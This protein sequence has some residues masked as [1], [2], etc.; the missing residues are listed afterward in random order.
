MRLAFLLAPCAFA[1]TRGGKL[2]LTMDDGRACTVEVTPTTSGEA[3]LMTNCA[4]IVNGVDV[5]A[6]AARLDAV[7]AHLGWLPPPSPP[8]SPLP[9]APPPPPSPPSAPSPSPP[10]IVAR[11]WQQIGSGGYCRCSSCS[12]TTGGASDF[13]KL[14]LP[15]T[16]SACQKACA[17]NAPCRAYECNFDG[18]TCELWT[19]V[20]DYSSGATTGACRLKP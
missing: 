4:V 12:S 6:L 7:E 3:T 9:S 2:S 5:E 20:P 16:C 10:P 14:S 11:P 18:S 13:T 19:T 1:Q 8:P 15:H 17:D